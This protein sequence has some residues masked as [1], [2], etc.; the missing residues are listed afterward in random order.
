MESDEHPIALCD[1]VTSPGGTTIEGVHMLKKYGF[2]H[3]VH[4]AIATQATLGAAQLTQESDE[5]P[6]ALCDQ[7]TS[8]GG[9]T[10]EGVHMLKK[11]GFETA[12]QQAIE[13]IIEKDR[14]LGE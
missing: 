6:I 7:V 4:E 8:P 5:H 9:T 1:Q 3:A 12:V 11:L 10:I 13:A 2:E 14:K